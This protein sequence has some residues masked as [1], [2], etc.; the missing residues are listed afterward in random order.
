MLEPVII[1][2]KYKKNKIWY[3]DILSTYMQQSILMVGGMKV[4]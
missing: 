1:L 4:L 2:W 3:K